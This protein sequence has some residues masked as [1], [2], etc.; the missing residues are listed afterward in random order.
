MHAGP[1]PTFLIIGAPKS[2]TTTLS[3]FLRFSPDVYI[4]PRKEIHFFTRF[5]DRGERWYRE[6]FADGSGAVAVGEASPEYL[7]RIHAHE[8]MASVVPDAKLVAIFRNPVERAYSQYWYLR[9]QGVNAPSFEDLARAEMKGEVGRPAL[10]SVGYYAAQIEHLTQY[11]DRENLLVLLLDDLQTDPEGVLRTLSGFVGVEPPPIS[12]AR[13]SNK[14]MEFRSL[15]LFRLMR[16]WKAW[17]RLPFGLG[18]RLDALN[19][20]PMAYQAMDPRL[21]RELVDHFTAHNEALAR[22]LDRD[23]SAW[24]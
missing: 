22:L 20:K 19:R 6:Q 3:D 18:S 11:Y 17:E 1:L 4:P 14:A 2:G 23:L 9:S 10:L 7:F 21:R 16:R 24:D 12:Q 13:A 15:R 5:Y 8:R